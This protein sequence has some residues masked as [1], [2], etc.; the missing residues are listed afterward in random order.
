MNRMLVIVPILLALSV[1]SL[2]TA[3][4]KP[5]S[6]RAQQFLKYMSAVSLFLMAC[7]LGLLSFTSIPFRLAHVCLLFGVAALIGALDA[8]GHYR[9]RMIIGGVAMLLVALRLW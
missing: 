4:R 2:V 3:A 7:L 6:G 9:I 8:D 1:W 5:V